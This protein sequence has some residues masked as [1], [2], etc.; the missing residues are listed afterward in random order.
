MTGESEDS[1]GRRATSWT[2]L[3]YLISA[4]QDYRPWISM[5]MV[6]HGHTWKGEY[7]YCFR[8]HLFSSSTVTGSH[9]VSS[10]QVQIRLLCGYADCPSQCDN[11]TGVKHVNLPSVPT[12]PLPAFSALHSPLNKNRSSP[13]SNPEGFLV[14]RGISNAPAPGKERHR[15]NPAGGDHVVQLS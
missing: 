11:V 12:S 4:H 9:I 14:V 10:C 7:R 6:V 15:P 8:R 5:L 13:E 3:E 2:K 1:E